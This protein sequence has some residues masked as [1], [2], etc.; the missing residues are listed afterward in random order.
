MQ[1]NTIGIDLAKNVF[2]IHGVDTACK[3]VITKKLR[4][5]PSRR[6]RDRR[7]SASEVALTAK[8]AESTTKTLPGFVAAA[9]T[10]ATAGP[11][12]KARL[13]ERPRSAFACWSRGFAAEAGGVE[14]A[15]EAVAAPIART[16]HAS[17]ATV[18]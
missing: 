8:V 6:V 12:T 9:I 7:R 11:T 18:A 2:Q 15:A 14:V 5:S 3:V 4:R 1:V 17:S 10:P 16:A 13:R